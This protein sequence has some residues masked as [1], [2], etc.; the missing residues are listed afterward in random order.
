MEQRGWIACAGSALIVC[1]VFLPIVDLPIAGTLTY[2]NHRENLGIV[3]LFL[4]VVS[5]VASM[6]RLYSTL[7]LTGAGTFVVLARTFMALRERFSEGRPLL[8]GT[9]LVHDS[10]PEIDRVFARTASWQWGWSVLIVGGA[11]LLVAAKGSVKPN[12]GLDA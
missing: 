8:S 1:G 11:L 5:V 10:L 3:L 6:R 4:A 9:R 7:W 12:S 2:F